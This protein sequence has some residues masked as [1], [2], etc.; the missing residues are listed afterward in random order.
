VLAMRKFQLGKLILRVVKAMIWVIMKKKA[1]IFYMLSGNLNEPMMQFLKI[2]SFLILPVKNNISFNC[3]MNEDVEKA[4][5]LLEVGFE[6]AVKDAEEKL[7]QARL[8][9]TNKENARPTK[10]L[11]LGHYI[12]SGFE[13]SESRLPNVQKEKAEVA[14]A[15]IGLNLLSRPD[16][17]ELNNI[18]TN[19]F[20]KYIKPHYN[21]VS[22]HKTISKASLESPS[23]DPKQNP[24]KREEWLNTIII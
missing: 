9:L 18:A 6:K 17:L 13:F 12:Q 22:N 1:F 2:K 19:E 8:N 11:K 21:L 10:D 24:E 5:A 7:K 20:E 16:V 23:N 14:E 15:E 4:K 3:I